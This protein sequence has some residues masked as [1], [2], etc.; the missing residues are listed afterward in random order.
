MLEKHWYDSFLHLSQLGKIAQGQ[1]EGI[2]I[3][4]LKEESFKCAH[5]MTGVIVI[6]F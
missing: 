2:I 6:S 3:V 1:N 5:K 4:F